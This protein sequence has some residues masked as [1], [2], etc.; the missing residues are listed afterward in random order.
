MTLWF[1]FCAA[2]QS[3]E[4]GSASALSVHSAAPTFSHVCTIALPFSEVSHMLVR[5]VEGK[6]KGAEINQW[7]LGGLQQGRDSFLSSLSG[8]HK[9]PKST[10]FVCAP[11]VNV[12]G[13]KP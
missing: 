13:Q 6:M 10:L 2:I 5:T 1:A 8:R 3:C 12:S 7:L 11:F 9:D 4:G